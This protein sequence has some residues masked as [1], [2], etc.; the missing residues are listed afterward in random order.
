MIEETLIQEQIAYYKQRAQEYDQWFYR[1]G[2]YDRGKEHRARW[3]AEVA[4]VR[5]RLAVFNPIGDVLEFAPGTGIWTQE[6]IAYADSV[7][8]VDTSAEMIAINRAKLNADRVSYIQTNIF[9]FEPQ[10][11]YDA[12]FFSFWLSHVPSNRFQRFWRIVESALKPGGRFFFIDS[13]YSPE[14]TA[15]DHYLNTAKDQVV[16]RKLNDGSEFNIVKIFYNAND[17]MQKLDQLGW[18]S[19]IVATDNFFLHG[20]GERKLD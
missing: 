15:R 9:Q 12:V 20:W 4:Q 19:T 3:G 11:Q 16:T 18:E 17:L 5:E 10:R 1:Q 13:L 8:A 14:S 7:V 6:L 2:R